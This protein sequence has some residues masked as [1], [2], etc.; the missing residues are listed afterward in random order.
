MLFLIGY[1]GSGKS[2]IANA[3]G[4]LKGLNYVDLDYYIEN[5]ENMSISRLFSAKG[6]IY[7]RKIESLYLKEIIE[8]REYDIV[9]LGGGTPC[10]ANNMNT[11][12][13]SSKDTSVYLKVNLDTLTE[14]L[15]QQK[16]GR[17]LLSHLETKADVKD[18]VRKHLFEREYHY[19][20]AQHIID[21]S[22]L[23]VQ[24]TIERILHVLE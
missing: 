22:D 11:I 18:F 15:F 12:N 20:Q 13:Q 8:K 5:K 19:R 9:A 7:F 6:E 10:Y 1:M 24:E 3:L 21:V 14:R 16:S 4:A 2:T 17:P 23:S